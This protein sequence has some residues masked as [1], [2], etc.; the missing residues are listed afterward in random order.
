[1]KKLYILF[2]A[3]LLMIAAQVSAH[4]PAEDIVDSDIYEN[5]DEMV[6]QTPHDTMIESIT[7]MTDM[8]ESAEIEAI[9]TK[10]S[11]NSVGSAESLINRGLLSFTSM[12][13]GDVTITIEYKRD[14]TVTDSEFKHNNSFENTESGV[15][16]DTPVTITIIQTL[17]E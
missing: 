8:M 17:P 5:I 3:C 7:P 13:T 14:T 15:W 12:L 16:W 6:S 9:V 10:I 1:M 2:A 11:T 4:H